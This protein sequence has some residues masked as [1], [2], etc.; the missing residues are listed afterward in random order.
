MYGADS[1]DDEDASANSAPST[2]NTTMSSA[3]SSSSSSS[4][5]SSSSSSSSSSLQNQKQQPKKRKRQKKMRATQPKE[6]LA[7]GYR[8]VYKAGNR[9]QVRVKWNTVMQ[10]VGVYNTKL[11]AAMAAD[12]EVHKYV[13]LY[14]WSLPVPS[15]FL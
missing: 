3:S 6:K 8:F 13:F 12:Y 4:L 7:S 11:E 10:Y 9:W 15:F 14:I 2:N 5:S 1:S